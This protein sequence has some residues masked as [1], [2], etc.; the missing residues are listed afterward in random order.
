MPIIR[1]TILVIVWIIGLVMALSNI[2]VNIGALLGTLGIGGIAFALAAQDTVKNV[3][4]AFTILTDKP[5]NIGDTIRVDNIEG[6]V[7][8][9]GVRSTK[10]MDY[11][12]RIITFPNYKV[13]DASIINISSEP[14]RRVVLKLGL[15]YNTTSDTTAVFTEYTDSA[16]N[17]MYIY[18]IEK[19]GDI[20]MVTSNVNME[21]LDSFNKAGIDF[22][23]PTR[24]IYVEKDELADLAKEKK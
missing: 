8:D 24:T 11:N 6:T 21:I 12:K 10:I 23:F 22:A 20:L 18:F 14:M 5:F 13:T 1:R 2:G 7:I 16:L 19:Q 15:T 3:F 17:I 9:V 4:G